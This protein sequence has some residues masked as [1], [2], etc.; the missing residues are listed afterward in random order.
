[1]TERRFRGTGWTAVAGGLVLVAGTL[2]AVSV[3]TADATSGTT[4]AIRVQLAYTCRFPSGLQQVGVT[5]A[6]TLPATAT[7]GAQIGP[8]GLRTTTTLPHTALANLTKLGA[9]QVTGSDALT[10]AVTDG[11]GAVSA[12]WPGRMQGTFP[13][14]AS[15]SL[16]L[17]GA[18]RVTP[19]TASSPGTVSFAAGSLTLTLV[20]HKASG[21]VTRPATLRVA[22]ALNP[23]QTTKLAT[24]P[25][26]GARPAPSA[27]PSPSRTRRAHAA[28]KPVK[29]PKGCGQIKRVDDTQL[30]C[31]F[32]TGYTDVRKLGD[33]VL[34]QPSPPK[35]PGLLNVDLDTKIIPIPPGKSCCT[36]TIS[37]GQLYYQGHEELPP[38]RATLLGFRFVPITATLQ[39]KE[40]K[41]IKILTVFRGVHVTITSSTL[42]TLQL[43]H[44]T[45]NGVPWENL[46]NRCQTSKPVK[47]TLVGKGNTATQKGFW[48]IA[49]G[50]PLTGDVTVPNFI[51]CG[52]GENLDPVI[53]VSIAGG[54]NFDLM[55]QGALCFFKPLSRSTCPPPAPK[56]KHSIGR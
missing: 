26:T 18:G 8:A 15:G 7:T 10:V 37:I 54:Q 44:A 55:T 27:S 33:A 11:T 50:G 45:V 2:A 3:A 22:C 24:V 21:A 16:P 14:P 42:V 48:N 31:G 52:V 4:Q 13:I 36:Q 23:E 5:V 30:T 39:I 38:V 56:P 35:K 12:T 32:I 41:P 47:L 28:A 43:S 19:V 9:A 51:D 49:A 29:F 20:P 17:T 34:L 1:M 6:A 53:N 40:L 25:V 46:G